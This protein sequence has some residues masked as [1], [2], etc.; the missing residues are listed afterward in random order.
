M[1]FRDVPQIQ[2]A[3]PEWKITGFSPNSSQAEVET[4][5]ILL[6]LNIQL[7]L[8]SVLQLLREP[9]HVTCKDFAL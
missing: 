3:I 4:L 9:L 6:I 8:K 7:S 5:L 1:D 2:A